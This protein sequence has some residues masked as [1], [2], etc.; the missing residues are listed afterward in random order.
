[1][2][3]NYQEKL[4]GVF[5]DPVDENPTV[6]I[7][8]AAFDACNLPFRYLTIQVKKGD[9]AAAMAGLRAMNFSGINITMPF[10]QEVLSLLDEV[11]EDAQIMGAVNTVYW[12]DG[13]LR[14]ENTDGKGFMRSLSDGGIDVKGKNAVVLG[15]GGAARAITV[16][17]ARA[18]VKKITVV[19]A[20][21]ANGEALV[22]LLLEKTGANAVYAS[23]EKPFAVPADTDILV[24]AT[25]VGFEDPSQRPNLD[26]STLK[27]NMVVCDVIPNTKHTRFL[28][29]AEAVGCKT[30]HGLQMLVNQGVLGFE[31]WTGQEAPVDVMAAALSAAYNAD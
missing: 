31:L 20:T 12:K 4:V 25:S 13:K 29:A 5:G 17:L 2:S 26:Y 27:A 18:G 21:Q 3:K 14:G 16:E 11:A 24:N 15:A 10:K 30:F 1:M 6:V 8:Q 7:Q 23:W 19:N 22:K 9:L 28:D